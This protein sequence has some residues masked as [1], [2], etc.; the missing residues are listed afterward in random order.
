MTG[1]TRWLTLVAI[2]AMV[3]AACGTD[4]AEPPSAED[5]ET[6]DSVRLQ[7][8]W[9]TQAQ[10]AGYYAAEDLGYY[11]AECLDVQII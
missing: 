10:F 3:V 6:T 1:K 5:C 7:L 2:L 8:Q 4:S 9:V 11:D